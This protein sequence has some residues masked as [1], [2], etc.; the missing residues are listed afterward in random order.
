M[1][2]HFV[3]FTIPKVGQ[4][5][6]A[7]I[8]YVNFLYLPF[9]A[10]FH[11]SYPILYFCLPLVLMALASYI[12]RDP[13]G[14]GM[15]WMAFLMGMY[16]A[17]DVL[18]IITYLIGGTVWDVW[19]TIY[20]GGLLAWIAT[21]LLLLYG[22]YHAH[23]LYTTVYH[24]TTHKALPNGKLRIL[25]I[26]DMHP[27]ST[28][29]PKRIPE[30]KEKIGALAPDIIVLT[31][32]IY[33]ENTT[34]TDFDAFN[35]FY[36]ELEAPYGKWFIYGN[37]DL[38]HHWRDPQ[39]DR[40][41]IERAFAAANVRVLEDV[42]VL[43]GEYDTPHPVRLVGRKDWLYTEHKRFSAE[44]M[45]PNGPDDIYTVWLDHEPRE[46]KDAAAAGADLILCGHTHG[47]QIWPLGLVS[48]LFRYNEV[49]YGRKQITPGCTCIVS[50]GT[51]TWSYQ[52]RTEGRTE[53]VCVDIV[54]E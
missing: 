53:L 40:A 8:L 12:S 46:L 34:R 25:Q 18:C 7:L 28:M 21:G 23:K 36:G 30:L 47:G 1:Y 26:S 10:M 51:G 2:S 16:I 20:A 45:M 41:D 15:I 33:D 49:N 52:I 11:E 35:K 38:G 32:D 31:G 29:T 48:R 37:H 22:W 13:L 44:Q 19:R 50:G 24:Q 43:A 5:I 54:T 9:I 6:V 3:Q 42:S 17:G 39:Y 27:G 4:I 14:T